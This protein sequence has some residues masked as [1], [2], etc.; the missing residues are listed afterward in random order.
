MIILSM[1]NEEI[2]QSF[3]GKLDEAFDDDELN[4]EMLDDIE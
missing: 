2:V 4:E 1:G 3:E